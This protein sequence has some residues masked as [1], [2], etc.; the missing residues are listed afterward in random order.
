MPF[1]NKILQMSLKKKSHFILI[2]V[3]N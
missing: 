3:Y 2:Y 1:H